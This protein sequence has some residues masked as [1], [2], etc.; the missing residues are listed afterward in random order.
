M[1]QGSLN[2]LQMMVGAVN[3]TVLTSNMMESLPQPPAGYLDTLQAEVSQRRADRSSSSLSLPPGWETKND[4]S[5]GRAYYV[6]HNTRTTSW[7]RPT[8]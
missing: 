8:R 2:M 5:S 3:P 6:D 1:P 7:L 4:A